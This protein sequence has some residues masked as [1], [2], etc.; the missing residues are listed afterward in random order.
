M[1]NW[2]NTE[3]EMKAFVDPLL[4]GPSSLILINELVKHLNINSSMRILDLGCGT[5][6]TSIYLAKQYSAQVI[7]SD[8]WISPTD[9]A[10]RFA[11]LEVDHLVTPIYAE[12]HQLPYAHHYFDL[13]IAIDSYHYFGHSEHYLED[14][15]IKHLK[16]G[17]TLAIVVPGLQEHCNNVPPQPLL[18]YWSEDMHFYSPSWWKKHWL[19]CNSLKQESIQAFELNSH[20][21]AWKEWLHCGHE[22]GIKDQKFIAADNGKYLNSVAVIAKKK[23]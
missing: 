18:T 19:K 17:G 12:A 15:L 8:L 2:F 13:I 4:M 21:A 11:Q 20:Q 10:I 7:A 14:H 16:P 1:K 6:L 22:Y 23:D 5:G 3:Q 9:N